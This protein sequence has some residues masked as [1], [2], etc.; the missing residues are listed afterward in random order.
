MCRIALK[1]GVRRFLVSI[2]SNSRPIRALKSVQ[3]ID[4]PSSE[5]YVFFLT[6]AQGKG[7][8]IL[9]QVEAWLDSLYEDA[10]QKHSLVQGILQEAQKALTS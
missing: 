6:S 5:L 3:R 9:T 8:E 2:I 10:G 1:I 4:E 7:Y